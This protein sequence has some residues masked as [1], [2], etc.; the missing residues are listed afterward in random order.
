M[1]RFLKRYWIFLLTFSIITVVSMG[2]IFELKKPPPSLPIYNPNMINASLV[3]S[4]I[5][6][7]RK[8]H[9]IGD[10]KLINQNGDTITQKDYQ[11]KIYVADF[12]YTTCPTICPKMTHSL[13]RVQE[14]TKNDDEIKLLSHT[15]TPEIDNVSRLKRYAEEHGVIDGKWNLVTGPKKAIYRLARKDYCVAKT[16]GDGGPYDMIHT[17][18]LALIDK[19][20][21]IRGFY[22]GTDPKEVDQLLKDIQLLKEL[23]AKKD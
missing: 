13:K 1:L 5:Q 7:I 4:S 12:F 23:E 16:Q 20:K 11:G 9:K 14:A 2:F 18:N 22:D 21:R 15:V 10:F 8:Y 3:D 17:E 6:Y 19:E